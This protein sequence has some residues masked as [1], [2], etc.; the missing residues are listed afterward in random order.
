MILIVD[1]NEMMIEVIELVITNIGHLTDTDSILTAS[2]GQ[3]AI[4]VA[5]QRQDIKLVLLDYQMPGMTGDAV[6]TEL[7]RIIPDLTIIFISAYT[8]EKFIE[9]ARQAGAAAYIAK[10]R[11]VLVVQDL[12][13]MNFEAL[14]KKSDGIWIFVQGN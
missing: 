2:S 11:L 8:D 13:A 1:D 14:K 6:A 7:R 4:A 12:V 10:D 3:E 5:R 9:A